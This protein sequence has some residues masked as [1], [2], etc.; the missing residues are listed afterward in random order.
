MGMVEA[1]NEEDEPANLV[2]GVRLELQGEVVLHRLSVLPPKSEKGAN[3]QV[4]RILR[5]VAA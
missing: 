2:V 4:R 3:D 1:T 5:F